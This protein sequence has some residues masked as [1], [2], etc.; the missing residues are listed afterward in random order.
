MVPA[1]GTRE[2]VEKWK[3]GFYH[4]A[5]NANVPVSFGFLDYGKKLAGVGDVYKLTG[6]FDTDM[7]Y[8]QD[9]YKK[10]EPRHPEKY[11]KKI[12]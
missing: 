4:I 10:I 8:I 11:N 6:V 3:T 7:K 2:R 1:E 5:K 9:Y 12:F